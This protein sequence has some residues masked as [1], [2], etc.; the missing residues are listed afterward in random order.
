MAKM[1]STQNAPSSKP[2]NR[3]CCCG[4][5]TAGVVVAFV[6]FLLCVLAIYGLFR[7]LHVFGLPY[8]FWFI[9]GI[10]SILIIFIAII[11]LLYAIKKEKARLLIPH[12]SA[13]IFLILFLL[14][15]VVVVA[16]LMLFGAYRGIRR[17]L[18]HG[19]YYM[20]DDS[21]RSLGYLIIVVYLA[22]AVLEIF[23]LYIIYKLYMYFREYKVLTNSSSEYY[24]KSGANPYNS[25][26]WY[27]APPNEHAY[28]GSPEAG[29]IYPYDAPFSP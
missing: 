5:K 1:D 3:I 14:I 22:V 15:V 23:F 9:V 4:L 25:N 20:S 8:L 26:E 29:D 16:L 24:S 2:P 6:E 19:D 7:N 10:I 13:Q 27:I 12:L 21:T 28:G 17:L 11:L 18:G